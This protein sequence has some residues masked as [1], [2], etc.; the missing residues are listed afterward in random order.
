MSRIP[1]KNFDA[2]VRFG[3]RRFD[4]KEKREDMFWFDGAATNHLSS[5]ELAVM[6]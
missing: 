3:G 1:I 6:H 5:G 4:S 2:T